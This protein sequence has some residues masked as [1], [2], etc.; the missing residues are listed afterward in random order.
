MTVGLEAPELLQP[1]FETPRR[2][3]AELG[4]WLIQKVQRDGT[5]DARSQTSWL[6]LVKS[7]ADAPVI[8]RPLRACRSK[9]P[10]TR[11]FLRREIIT[12]LGP[13]GA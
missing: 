5:G 7:L 13:L 8:A 6:G 12:M 11:L 10:V 4:A 1:F 3:S 2:S 9:N